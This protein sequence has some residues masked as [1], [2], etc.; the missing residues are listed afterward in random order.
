[1]LTVILSDYELVRIY[2]PDAPSGRSTPAAERHKRFQAIASAYDTLKKGSTTPLN[3]YDYYSAEV[4]RRRRMHRRQHYRH[5]EY[6]YRN[7]PGAYDWNTN[8]D[9][10]WKDQLIIAF[11]LVVRPCFISYANCQG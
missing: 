1:M 9:D 2:H 7:A 10:R 8:P 3:D 4:E 11:G 5:A 6:T